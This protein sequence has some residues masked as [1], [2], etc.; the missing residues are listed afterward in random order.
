MRSVVPRIRSREQHVGEAELAQVATDTAWDTRAARWLSA[1]ALLGATGWTVLPGGPGTPQLLLGASAA[2]GAA[3][4]AARSVPTSILFPGLAAGAGLTAAA[5][6]GGTLMTYDLRRTGV[7]L[8]ALAVAALVWAARLAL[9]A[10]ASIVAVQRLSVLLCASGGAATL[11]IT[12]ATATGGPVESGLGAAVTAVLALR[13]RAHHRPAQRL[14]LLLAGAGGA[15]M[16]IGS[17]AR[18]QPDWGP[19]LFAILLLACSVAVMQRPVCS[20]LLGESL[21]A[22]EYA[23][24]AAVLPVAGWSL[25]VFDL[26]GPGR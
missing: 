6:L 22:L 2:G 9:T 18:I 3:A 12:L 14:G 11:G 13:A 5:A 21:T 19:W 20:P 1:V 15:V 26:L 23:G 24:L 17:M 7:L 16:T 8:C 10:S 4:V 25:G